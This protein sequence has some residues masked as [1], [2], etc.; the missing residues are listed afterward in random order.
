MSKRKQ[1]Y[2]PRIET[3]E[4]RTVPYGA[5]LFGPQVPLEVSFI[6][7]QSSSLEAMGVD[8]SFGGLSG[9]TQGYVTLYAKEAET[10]RPIGSAE[11]FDPNQTVLGLGVYPTYG[12]QVGADTPAL[13]V[14]FEVVNQADGSTAIFASAFE[15]TNGNFFGAG[16]VLLY[17][18]QPIGD[19]PNVFLAQGEQF[20]D[21]PLAGQAPVQQVVSTRE[22]PVSVDGLVTDPAQSPQD[23]VVTPPSEEPAPTTPAAETQVENSGDVQG[24]PTDAATVDNSGG[25]TFEPLQTDLLGAAGDG[26]GNPGPAPGDAGG[27][28]A[29]PAD[30]ATTPFDFPDGVDYVDF[31]G[32]PAENDAGE[33]TSDAA[34]LFRDAAAG[35]AGQSEIEIPVRVDWEIAKSEAVEA[36][37]D[38]FDSLGELG[39]NLNSWG[40]D[41]PQKVHLEEQLRL[42]QAADLDNPDS[43]LN[44]KLQA[45]RD[46]SAHLDDVFWQGDEAWRDFNHDDYDPLAF[47][48]HSALNEADRGLSELRAYRDALP[49]FIDAAAQYQDQNLQFNVWLQFE[50]RRQRENANLPFYLHGGFAMGGAVES[51]VN[52]LVIEPGKQVYD[53]GVVVVDLARGT[54]TP[55]VSGLGQTSQMSDGG[56]FGVY[57]DVGAGIGHHLVT[58]PDRVAAALESGDPYVFGSVAMD[59]YMSIQATQRFARGAGSFAFNRSVH[60]MGRV[61]EWA[62]GSLGTRL[63]GWRNAIRNWQVQQ[64]RQNFQAGARKLGYHFPEDIPP[65]VRQAFQREGFDVPPKANWVYDPTYDANTPGRY[66]P[67]FFEAGFPGDVI[68]PE[69]AFVKPFLFEFR[70]FS[71][72]KLDNAG[73]AHPNGMSPYV[74]AG[75]GPLSIFN[76]GYNI[77]LRRMVKG[78]DANHV[79][80]HEGFHSIQDAYFPEFMRSN[81]LAEWFKPQEFTLYPDQVMPGAHPFAIHNAPTAGGRVALAMVPPLLGVSDKVVADQFFLN[82]TGLGSSG[83]Q[84]PRRIKYVVLPMRYGPESQ[85]YPNLS[86]FAN[87]LVNG[88]FGDSAEDPEAVEPSSVPDGSK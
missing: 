33:G 79:A 30:G 54:N 38:L 70:P 68:I 4:T 36:V 1:R 35:I 22:E 77:G 31:D 46:A 56:V 80:W 57:A 73:A 64:L 27:D 71:R 37:V 43:D 83:Y 78:M 8:G 13:F 44:R 2:L 88:D 69:S 50:K 18:N 58:T 49:D 82:F 5:D 65:A 74:P 11:T 16:G 53:T 61:G 23:P 67:G 76:P 25:F 6:E 75:Q 81:G 66:S 24:T 7:V 26:G 20:I 86:V 48:I 41:N 19:L 34:E 55:L 15:L 17:P 62:G 85:A 42:L 12:V 3:L 45:A 87:T 39:E 84:P 10:G 51:A 14:S 32:I 59:G 52:F 72:T 40:G 63:V 29:D 47:K 21:V 9:S 28:P 60:W